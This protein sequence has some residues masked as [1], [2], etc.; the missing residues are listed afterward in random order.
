MKLFPDNTPEEE[1]ELWENFPDDHYDIGGMMTI[2][3][4]KDR[5]ENLLKIEFKKTTN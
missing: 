5:L 3:G 2:R 4:R 1:K